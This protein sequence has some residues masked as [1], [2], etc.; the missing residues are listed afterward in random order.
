MHYTLED[1]PYFAFN[2]SPAIPPGQSRIA[3]YG[4]TLANMTQDFHGFHRFG[5]CYLLRLHP[6]IIG[7]AGRIGLLR[8][9][10]DMLQQ[11]NVWIATAEQ[12]AAHWQTQPDNDVCH[13]AEVFTRIT[14]GAHGELA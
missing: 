5:L 4:E 3:P 9:L 10:L 8:A 7:T 14:G 6:E 2:L 11:H 12:A 13:P 1:E